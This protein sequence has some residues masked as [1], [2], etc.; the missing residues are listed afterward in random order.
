V[1]GALW[2]RCSSPAVRGSSAGCWCVG[3]HSLLVE[4]LVAAAK[5]GRFGWIDGARHTTEVT[6]VD[7]A[8]EGPV[9]GWQRGRPG[10]AYIRHRPPPR[11]PA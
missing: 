11:H 8:V 10:Q 5:A 3:P 4:G 2:C 1:E 9:L 6:F 7:N